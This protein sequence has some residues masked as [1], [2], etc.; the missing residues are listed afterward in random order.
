[1]QPDPYQPPQTV[2]IGQQ[3][4][5]SNNPN[6]QSQVI[7]VQNQPSVGPTIIGLFTIIYGVGA[8]ILSIIGLIALR[9]LMDESSVL[10]D[11][12]FAENE[13]FI[14]A[15]GMITIIL[16]IGCIVGGAMII[17]RKKM[18][19]YITWGM[20]G[21]MTFLNII[22]ELIAPGIGGVE[23][24]PGMNILMQSFCGAFCAILV[25]VPLMD[26]GSNMD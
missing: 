8:L 13:G 25:A 14:M 22:A 7:Y 19:V 21:A 15:S 16:L 10:Y 20:I 26:T 24:S 1:M 17:Q 6:A 23:S 9:L 11:P 4:P 18:G 3:T 2:V 5:F 12:I